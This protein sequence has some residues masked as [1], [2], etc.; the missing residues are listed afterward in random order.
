MAKTKHE[1]PDVAT[2]NDRELPFGGVWQYAP[3][4]ESS[5]HVQIAPRHELFVG[6]EWVKP[7]SGEHFATI[8]PATEN[9]LSEVAC[10]GD[11]DVDAAVKAAA[12]AFPAWRR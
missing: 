10:A 8:E 4:K 12:K 11:K 7:K 1:R 5:E 9:V 3:A 6:G 2:G